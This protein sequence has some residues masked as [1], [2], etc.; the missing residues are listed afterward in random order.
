MGLEHPAQNP[1]GS[2]SGIGKGSNSGSG[3]GSDSDS[4]S[5]VGM[6]SSTILRRSFKKNTACQKPIKKTTNLGE[7]RS[8][9]IEIIMS[10]KSFLIVKN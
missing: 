4:G 9:W 3:S 2:G 10:C 8:S 7:Y 5:G 6:W 1:Q